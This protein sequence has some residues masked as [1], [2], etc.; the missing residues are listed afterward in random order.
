M[1]IDDIINENIK[2]RQHEFLVKA[3]DTFDSSSIEYHSQRRKDS[4]NSRMKPKKIKNNFKS[5]FKNKKVLARNLSVSLFLLLFIVSFIIIL[6]CAGSFDLGI[7][8]KGTYT[9]LVFGI[10][11]LLSSIVSGIITY[12]IS[13]N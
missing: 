11:L 5:L 12:L 9:S 1:T 7:E 10:I 3:I 4:V 8:T 2:Q 13:K 6:G